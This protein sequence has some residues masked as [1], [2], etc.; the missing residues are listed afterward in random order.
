MLVKRIRIFSLATVFALLVSVSFL[1]C[2]KKT[3]EQKALI[4]PTAET[5]DGERIA[6]PMGGY[7][8]SLESV[9]AEYAGRICKA[10]GK[11]ASEE[12]LN[13]IC[14]EE[15]IVGVGLASVVYFG[16]YAE[17]LN[18]EEWEQ[19]CTI[20]EN[21]NKNGSELKDVPNLRENYVS[22]IPDSD[23]FDAM[24]ESVITDYCKE[25][26]CSRQEAVNVIYSG[27]VTIK[28]PYNSS[29]QTI[30]DEVYSDNSNFT[31]DS[32]KRFPQSACA[33]LDY[34]GGVAAIT[35]GNNGN[36]AYNRSYRIPHQ[37]GSSVKPLSVYA[38]A[39]DEKLINFSSLIP[40]EP[41]MFEDA[42][43]KYEWPKNYDGIY[44]GEITVTYA[45]RTSRNAAA[46]QLANMLTPSYC[47][48]FMQK[49][50]GFTTLTDD[51]AT[52]AAMALGS[53]ENGA[54]LHELAAAYAV[55][56]NGGT[57]YEPHFYTEVTD[58]GGNVILRKNTETHQALDSDTAWIM[59]RLLYYNVNTADGIANAAALDNTE[60]IGKTGTAANDLNLDSGRIFVGAV[61]DYVTAVWIGFDDESSMED[62]Q[63]T[64]PTEVWKKMAEQ[65]P[66]EHDKFTPDDK[67]TEQEYCISSGGLAVKGLCESETGYYTSDNMPDK[68]EKCGK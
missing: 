67:V 3:D 48:D 58:S 65:L 32:E 49:K 43:G 45:L 8:V 41:L 10:Y 27:G 46:A 19:F 35:G 42:D 36:H 37:L 6:V 60:V 54:Y 64:P 62:V 59:N 4:P 17:K 56:G 63:Y 61:P 57:Y 51:D 26:G 15:N 39:L 30:V 14:F 68:C 7:S 22:H 23:Y 1:S 34:S 5:S 44:D 25:K 38:P 20:A 50:F 18:D 52:Y 66:L 16:K 31:P 12:N 2:G 29:I 28:T 40:D 55:F 9:P 53:L 47:H 13:N 33:V 21:L 11:D 24:I